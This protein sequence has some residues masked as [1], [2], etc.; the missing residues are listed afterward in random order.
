MLGMACTK[1]KKDEKMSHLQKE[2]YW[3]VLLAMF[4]I[5]R[6]VIVDTAFFV[7]GIIYEYF[8]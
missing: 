8:K 7:I 4:F 1:V 6:E 5:E 3:I 2:M